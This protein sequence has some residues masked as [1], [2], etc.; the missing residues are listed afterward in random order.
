[1]NFDLLIT[2]L[3]TY[4]IWLVLCYSA[5]SICLLKST[6]LH[7]VLYHSIISPHCGTGQHNTIYSSAIM[8]IFNDILW[9]IMRK[10]LEHNRASGKESEH[11][12]I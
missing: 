5:C 3:L 12:I 2:A 4:P 1:M 10:I 11:S 9:G 7:S 8:T 6:L